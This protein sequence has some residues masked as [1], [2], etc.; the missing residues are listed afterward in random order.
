FGRPDEREIDPECGSL[1]HLAFDFDRAAMGLDD[2]VADGQ[3]QPRP[4]SGLGGEKGIENPPEVFLGYSTSGIGD[5]EFH[6][7]HGRGAGLRRFRL[8][9]PL[10]A[11]DDAA[12][13]I[14]RVLGVDKQVY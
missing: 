5:R 14:N 13:S 10:R 9:Y 7:R 1:T 12:L 6:H 11:D 2:P 4:Y 3:S 8:W